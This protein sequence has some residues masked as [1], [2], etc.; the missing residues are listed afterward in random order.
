MWVCNRNLLSHV[1]N[2]LSNQSV[3]ALLCLGSWSQLGLVK[4][5]DIRKVVVM[6]DV[7]GNE[8]AELPDGWDAID[9]E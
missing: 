7:K 2:R 1:R 8:D 5:V 6:D 9:D 4:D 3:R